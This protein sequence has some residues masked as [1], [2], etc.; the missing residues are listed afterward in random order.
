MAVTVRAIPQEQRADFI[1]AIAALRIEIFA[2]WPYL[3]EG[4]RA[5]EANYLKTYLEADGAFIAGAFD[6]DI[7]VGVC[8]AAPL[9]QHEAAFIEPL[10]AAGYDPH[11]LFYLGESVLRSA[12][13]GQGVGVAFF[14]E[15]EAE[16]QRQGFAHA[17][18][19]A[20]RRPDT[21]P[22]KP[23]D[24]VALDGFWKRR[25]YRRLDGVEAHYGW[26]DI[27][28]TAETRKPMQFWH[29]TLSPFTRL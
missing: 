18:F 12:Y 23:V 19:C 24:Y 11:A 16:A 21:H 20:V 2:D 22:A 29:K 17:V 10:R 5:Y 28:G 15:R 4:D 27:G 9:G 25:G 3:Y 13:R 6:G 26:R 7:L 1:D 14:A 8:T